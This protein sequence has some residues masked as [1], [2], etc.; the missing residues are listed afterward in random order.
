MVTVIVRKMVHTILYDPP[1]NQSNYEKASSY[2]LSYNKGKYLEFPNS[3][4]KKEDNNTILP[5][6]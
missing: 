2:Q 5:R 4:R 3:T 1:V 6:K